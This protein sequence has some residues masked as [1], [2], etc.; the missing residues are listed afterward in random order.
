MQDGRSVVRQL[1]TTGSAPRVPLFDLIRNDAV[2]AHFAGELVTPDNG[3]AI[4]YRVLPEIIDAT[5]S[6]RVPQQESTETRPDGR[7]VQRQRWTTWT[8]HPAAVDTVR[9]AAELRQRLAVP[10]EVWTE[11]DA[12]HLAALVANHRQAAARLGDDFFLMAGSPAAPHLHGLMHNTLG[13]EQFCYLL[14]DEPAVVSAWLEWHT[15]RGLAA[16]GHL[17]ADAGIEAVMIGEDIAWKSGTMVAPEWL[18]REFI[19]RLARIVAA[20]HEK[21]IKVMYHSDGNLKAVLPALVDAGIDMLNPIEIAAGMDPGSIH[22]RYPHLIQVGAIDVSQLLPLGTPQQVAAA[23]RR[24]IDDTEG[25]IMIGSSTEL[26][27]DV[28]LAN[29]LAMR[30]AVLRTAG[31]R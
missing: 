4:L 3:E 7:L 22:R 28:P 27:N 11:S 12:R 31:R 30:D 21:G 15:A 16:V 29:F 13:V 10:P 14:L 25:K 23:V 1:I 5:R 6:L 18:H 17:P 8:A 24:T 2:L 19:P 20:L 9:F 26:H